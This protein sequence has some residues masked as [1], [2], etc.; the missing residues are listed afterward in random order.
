MMLPMITGRRLP[1][2]ARGW[3]VAVFAPIA[4]AVATRD[5]SVA[6]R[7]PAGM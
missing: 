6:A 1:R 3:R 4:V 2:K 5:G 7:R